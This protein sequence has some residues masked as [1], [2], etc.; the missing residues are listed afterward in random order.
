LTLPVEI[1]TAADPV[2]VIDADLLKWFNAQHTISITQSPLCHQ[3]GR[4]A[5]QLAD[6]YS[7]MFTVAK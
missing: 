3:P 5:M 4:L 2:I 1:T 7:H 6:N